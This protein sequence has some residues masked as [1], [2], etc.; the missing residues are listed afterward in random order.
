[1]AASLIFMEQKP[2][3]RYAVQLTALYFLSSVFCQAEALSDPTRPPAEIST[4]QAQVAAPKEPGLQ[5]V[6]IS[7]IRRAAIIN[8]QTVELGGRF[9]NSRLVEVNESGIIL[10]GAQGRRIMAL[11]P[12]VEL[13]SRAAAIP[14]AGTLKPPVKNSQ[15]AP[16]TGNPAASEEKR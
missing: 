7:P 11:F 3:C 12:G 10:E 4:P 6:Y 5:S 16:K 13:V 15:P 2:C 14:E 1:M 9:G 8:G